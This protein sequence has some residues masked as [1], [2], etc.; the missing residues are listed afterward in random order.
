M[1]TGLFLRVCFNPDDLTGD[2]APPRKL[3]EKFAL[4]FI[5]G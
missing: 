2:G 1:F 3:L 4:Y 5:L